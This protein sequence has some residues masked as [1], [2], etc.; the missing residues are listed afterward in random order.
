MAVPLPTTK[1]GMLGTFADRMQRRQ[2]LLAHVGSKILK[3]QPGRSNHHGT[4][5]KEKQ[6]NT[7]F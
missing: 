7:Y 5:K 1:I 3:D 2:F 4:G 6:E